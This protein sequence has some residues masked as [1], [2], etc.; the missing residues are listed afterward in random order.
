MICHCRHRI[1][2]NLNEVGL[3]AEPSDTVR[4][5]ANG[6]RLTPFPGRS[7][8]YE[9]L[10]VNWM[11]QAKQVNVKLYALPRFS[12]SQ[13]PPGTLFQRDGEL[14]KSASVIKLLKSGQVGKCT[15]IAQTAEG[16]IKLEANGRP[17]RIGLVAQGVAEGSIPK[18]PPRMAWQW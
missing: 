5:L 1:Q 3:L 16:G 4:Q 15:P 12:D 14:E 17:T 2:L 11:K 7:T 13:L 18:F 10:L 9:F 6:M 8:T